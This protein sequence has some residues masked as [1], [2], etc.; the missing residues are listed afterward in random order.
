ME[1]CALYC[2]QVLLSLESINW[3]IRLH[4]AQLWKLFKSFS[5]S[6]LLWMRMS[7]SGQVMHLWCVLW[8][9]T[10]PSVLL[11]CPAVTFIGEGPSARKIHCSENCRIT[12]R[13]TLH[14]ILSVTL[15]GNFSTKCYCWQSSACC[16]GAG[17]L[18][19]CCSFSTVSVADTASPMCAA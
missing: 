10:D 2:R 15:A 6:Q 8:L 5:V 18:W 9:L 3:Q 1:Y 14:Q 11:R 4:V 7:V 13:K 17:C 12:K 19:V 16:Y